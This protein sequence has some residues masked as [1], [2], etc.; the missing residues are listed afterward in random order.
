MMDGREYQLSPALVRARLAG[1]TPGDIRQY[2]VEIDGVRWP[3]KQVL[4]LA[5]GSTEFQSQTAQRH[6]RNLGFVVGGDTVPPAERSNRPTPREPFELDRLPVIESVNVQGSF[7]W[8]L[9][10]PITLDQSGT[11][12]FPPMPNLPGLYRFDFGVDRSGIRRLYV[13]ESDDLRRRA[14]NYRNA[15]KDGGNNRTSRRIHKELVTHLV[16]GGGIEFAIT[17]N[18]RIVGDIAA[19]LRLKSARRL[20]ENAAVLLAQTTPG[21]RALNIDVDLVEAGA[22]GGE[23]V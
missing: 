11:P 14:S 10:G 1:Q 7:D 18:V 16:A 12:V 5:T 23:T 15:K 13:G 4:R 6:L 3:V 9:A 8:H 17:T 2:W 19:D 22:I 20:A 21:I